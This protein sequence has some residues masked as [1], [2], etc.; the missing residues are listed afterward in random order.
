[1]PSA[2]RASWIVLALLG[3]PG[4]WP[5]GLPFVAAPLTATTLSRFQFAEVH[6]GMRVTVTLYA[7][8]QARAEAGARAAFSRIAALDAMLSDYRS[9]SELSRLSATHGAWVPV[10]PELFAV[11]S[12]A[13]DIAR[14]T[15]GAF[16]PTIGPLTLVWRE[17]RRTSRVP[18]AAV[19]EQAR[20]R[21]GWQFVQL[22]TS[23]QAVRLD[24]A[25]MR[26]DLGGIAKGFILQEGLAA[27]DALGLRIALL[28]AGGDIVC[29]DAPPGLPGWR[30]DTPGADD[31]FAAR[32][33]RLTRAAL[34]ASGP[35]AQ[36][37]DANG[38][39]YSHVIDP[40]TGWGVTSPREV[41][42]IA[43]DA[44]TADAL[45]TALG[46]LAPAA[47][48]AVLAKFPDVIWSP[49]STKWSPGL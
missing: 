9:D 17:A 19:I 10:S 39:R 12:R 4:A 22:D 33:S 28:D 11:L 1:M 15:D 5:A 2:L 13:I 16:D 44:A 37:L 38:V 21:V 26:L 23:R 48:R 18:D 45:A 29:G 3:T 40:R 30:I 14:A 46:V 43:P 24:R 27:L 41:R 6:M 31:A 47:A 20:A 34:A 49:G 25:G 8:D 32:A 7:P 36:F 35:A 42:V